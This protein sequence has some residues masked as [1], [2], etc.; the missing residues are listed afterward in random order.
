MTSIVKGTSISSVVK[1][2][3][4]EEFVSLGPTMRVT[5]LAL[6]YGTQPMMEVLTALQADHWLHAIPDRKTSLRGQKLSDRCAMR[7]TLTR[8]RGRQ[9]STGGQQILY[10]GR[11]AHWVAPD[12]IQSLAS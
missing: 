1:G 12:E 2:A 10:C 7:S 6:E 11:V 4:P 8:Q 9:P 3:L 5:Y